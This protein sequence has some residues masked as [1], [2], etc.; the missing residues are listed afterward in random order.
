VERAL[1]RAGGDRVAIYDLENDEGTPIYVHA[2]VCIVDDTWMTVGSDNL[3]RRSWTHDSEICC[4]VMDRAGELPR[5]TRVRLAREHLDLAANG[6]DKLH[7]HT[8]WIAALCDGATALDEWHAAGRIGPRPR[9]RLRLHPR[10]R[11]S[12]ASRVVL[13]QLHAR[14]LDPDGRPRRL[15]ERG[16]Y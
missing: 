14:L 6:D 7:D 16:R 11:V 1:F 8:T 4:A 5:E 15:R 2:K 3:N 10:D 12:A 13:H 9:G